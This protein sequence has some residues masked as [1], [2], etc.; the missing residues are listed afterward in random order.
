MTEERA[1]GAQ[2]SAGTAPAATTPVYHTLELGAGTGIC[3]LVAAQTGFAGG[4]VCFTDYDDDVLDLLA[5]NIRANASGAPAGQQS[6]QKLAWGSPDAAGGMCAAALEKLGIAGG[7]LTGT[8]ARLLVL[9]SDVLY[10]T[11][12]VRPFLDTVRELF[13]QS[14]EQHGVPALLLLSHQLRY[15]V[16]LAADREIVVQ[17]ESVGWS[18]E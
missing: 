12:V 13:R 14:E 9:A 10:T 17:A 5:V 18:I 2:Q 7:R 3:G 8:R 11:C 15:T 6:A 1:V 16:M 4:G